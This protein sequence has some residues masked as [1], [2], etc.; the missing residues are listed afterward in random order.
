MANYD[1]H[2]LQTFN[3]LVL[4]LH[5]TGRVFTSRVCF[6]ESILLIRY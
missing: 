6:V 3:G 1:P 5:E 4:Q 2:G